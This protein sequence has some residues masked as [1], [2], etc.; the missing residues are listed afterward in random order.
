MGEKGTNDNTKTP[1][2]KL[3]SEVEIEKRIDETKCTTPKTVTN[4]GFECAIVIFRLM[5][6]C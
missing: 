2:N 6:V 1:E 4:G 3:V 5:W